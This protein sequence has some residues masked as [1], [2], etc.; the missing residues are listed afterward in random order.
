MRKSL[1]HQNE[2]GITLIELLA[3]IV[4]L[5]IVAAIAVPAIGNI[6]ENAKKDAHIAN[7]RVMIEAT[8]LLSISDSEI[9]PSNHGNKSFVPL[10]YLI[11]EGYLDAFDSH[12]FE[13]YA[14]TL[15]D[16]PTKNGGSHHKWEDEK[17]TFVAIEN[18]NGK[19]EYYVK[20]LLTPSNEVVLPLT[21]ESEITRDKIQHYD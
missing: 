9:R 16:E 3:V 5:G 11:N 7:A 20:I 8:R 18:N 4:I 1:F 15:I 2:K 19:I 14:Q 21:K 12:G 6:I 10:G 17:N 13:K